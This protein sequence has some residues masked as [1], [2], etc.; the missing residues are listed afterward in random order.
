MPKQAKHITIA[1]DV[2]GGDHGP[3]VVLAGAEISRKRYP[4]IRYILH[5]EKA[6]V[7]PELEKYA[8]LKAESVF[9]DCE[10]SITMVDKPSQA[11]RRGRRVFRHVEGA[12]FR[13]R[14]GG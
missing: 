2:M 6:A 9:H 4:E 14:R 8:R 10:H 13:Q 5:G 1:L 12:G 7:L 11:L 3:S